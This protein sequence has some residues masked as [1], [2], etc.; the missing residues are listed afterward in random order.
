[1]LR[2]IPLSLL[3]F[4]PCSLS[5]LADAPQQL[6][7]GVVYADLNRN[8]LRDRGEPGLSAVRVSNGRQI[9]VTD[10][11][12]QYQIPV[13]DD[14]IVF[15]IKPRNWMVPVDRNH[16]PRFYY[17]HKPQGSPKDLKYAGVASTGPLPTSI[18]FPLIK[19]PEPDQFKVLVFGDPQ[20]NNLGDIYH[21]GH[22]V[23]AEL[24]GTDA[25]FGLTMGDVMADLLNLYPPYNEVM[26]Q[27]G[28]PL[29]NTL[30]NH[31]I[32][33]D[34]PGDELSDETWERTYGPATYSLD[35]GP[36]H[37]IVT[38]NVYYG[39]GGEQTGGG[40]H[41]EFIPRVL[42]FV[43]NDLQHVP[44]DQLVVIAMHIP[45]T[46]ANH[47][48][49][50]TLLGD[51]PHTFSL[52]GHSHDIEQKFVQHEVG[53]PE[54]KE[55]H[56]VIS[57]A[58]CGIHWLGQPDEYGIPHA[59]THCGSPNGYTIISFDG[60][61]YKMRFKAPRRPADDQLH[62]YA[63]SEVSLGQTG[64]TE[65]L[66]NVYFGNV[67]NK[68]EMRLDD[69][70]WTLMRQ[71]LRQDPFLAKVITP[72]H[73]LS[74]VT[75]MWVANLP[76]GLNRG[77]HTIHVRTTDMF[78]QTFTRSR[79]LRVVLPEDAQPAAP[80][81]VV[82]RRFGQIAQVR[83]DKLDDF[84]RL[85][86]QMGPNL[87]QNF[88]E[89]HVQNHSMW[90][91]DLTPGEYYAFRFFQYTGEDF[92]EERVRMKENTSIRKWEAACNACLTQ[93][94]PDDENSW[95]DM[96]EVFFFDGADEVEADPAVVKRFGQVIGVR[97][98]LV[99]SYKLIHQHAWPEVLAAIRRGN[100]R[101]Y[102]IYM[103][104]VGEKVYIFG[105]FEYVGT[106]FDTDMAAIDADPATL[107]WMKFTDQAC[108][109]PL[110]TRKDGEWWTNMERIFFQP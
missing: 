79:V 35:W 36:V 1:M 83:A 22:D 28:I 10:D 50:L 2:C 92:P 61:T 39:G 63:P 7:Q 23:V 29:W 68:T 54:L 80:E 48:D 55:H 8:Q 64:T 57:G 85:H 72:G 84:K 6:A 73:P 14:T 74:Q 20:P 40:Y 109:L 69:G 51:R 95:S 25:A 87:A 19:H 11:D 44:Q 12:G 41:G 24:I 86:A 32:N 13:G 3:A 106:D 9:V 42:E 97:P 78:G 107:A 98:E 90:L 46:D 96:E 45:L 77:G 100:I 30:G 34:V 81:K 52:S 88:R 47:N 82:V 91:K 56:H 110:A 21:L 67:K 49:L 102:P 104:T 4:L 65:V 16:V 17:I 15:V 37:F 5:A 53:N 76:E 89:H 27:I 58:L 43:K 38:D 71:E 66:A 101:N 108:Q 93:P 31:D 26:G 105:Y 60:N 18:D 94:D 70:S 75:H 103:T 99:D 59:M 62:I 33:F